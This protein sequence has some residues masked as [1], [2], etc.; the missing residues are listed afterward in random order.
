MRNVRA[1]S[2]G[3][4]IIADSEEEMNERI[5][6]VLGDAAVRISA[7]IGDAIDSSG[8]PRM[9]DRR[10]LMKMFRVGRRSEYINVALVAFHIDVSPLVEQSCDRTS[11]REE[12][13][14][15]TRVCLEEGAGG[16]M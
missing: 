7:V 10:L 1:V 15:I 9:A 8:N 2:I 3:E 5:N 11:M 13:F 14:L 12:G 6:V 16:C 4:R